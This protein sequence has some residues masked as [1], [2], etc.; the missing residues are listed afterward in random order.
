MNA[1]QQC[2]VEAQ[3][4]ASRGSG[5]VFENYWRLLNEN[6]P[7]HAEHSE[8]ARPMARWYIRKGREGELWA[9]AWQLWERDAT[10]DGLGDLRLVV[11]DWES[12]IRGLSYH[13]WELGRAR[14]AIE[15]LKAGNREKS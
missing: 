10:K 1:C 7:Y 2:W 13:F 11:R 4:R 5:E 12:C 8:E 14:R 6:D 3:R 9:G 15:A